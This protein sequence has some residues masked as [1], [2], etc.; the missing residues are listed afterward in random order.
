MFREFYAIISGSTVNERQTNMKILLA[1]I[2]AKYIHSNPAVY[3]LAAFAGMEPQAVEI[4]EFTINQYKEEIL[5]SI[6]KARADVVMFSCYIWNIALVSSVSAM[7]KAAAPHVHIWLGGPEVSYD[8]PEFLKNHP[9][10]EGIMYG[11]GEYS[12]KALAE[13]YVISLGALENV[14]GVV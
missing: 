13:Y 14:P 2:N 10:I 12:F 5:E 3:T 11:E 6:Y 1:A 9:H 8:A 7:L 4:R